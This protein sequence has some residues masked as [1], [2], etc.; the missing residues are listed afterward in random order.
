MT[1]DELVALCTGDKTP[2][3][4]QREIA[5]NGLPE[6]LTIPT[7]AGKTMAVVLGWLYRRRYHPDL[8]RFAPD[9]RPA[10]QRRNVGH[11]EDDRRG[12]RQ[13]QRAIDGV[14]RIAC[15]RETASHALRHAAGR[16]RRHGLPQ[17]ALRAGNRVQG[18]VAR[19]HQAV[20]K[21]FPGRETTLRRSK[22]ELQE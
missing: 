6:L 18:W 5:A 3:E 14:D 16:K 2:Y 11:H 15:N 1:Y 10:H 13:R 8:A 4:Y 12:Q 22:M 19:R 9:G 20:G 17:V 21:S 7:G